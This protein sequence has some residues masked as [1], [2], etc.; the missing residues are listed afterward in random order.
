[1]R[2]HGCS[3]TDRLRPTFTNTS[4][5]RNKEV[6]KIYLDYA[7]TCPV[8]PEVLSAMIPFFCDLFGNPSSFHS[9]GQDAKKALENARHTVACSIG[10]GP[11]EVVFTSGGTESDN[12]AIKGV[13]YRN[14]S[15]GNHI[16][17]S[18]IEHHAVLNPCRFLQQEGFDVTVLPVDSTGTVDPDDVRKAITPKTVLISVM[19][20][21]NEIGTIEPIAVIG[22]IARE[23]EVLFHTDAVQTYGHLPINVEELHTDLLSASAHKLYGPKGVG[24]LY[25]KKG[26]KIASFMHGGE[27]EQGRRGS[28]HNLPG[29]VGLGKAAEIA[30]RLMREED[31]KQKH[32]RD[33]LIRG[34][35]ERIPRTKLNGHPV[36]RLPNNVNI[37]VSEVEG[38][39]MMLE[40]DMGGIIC[41]TGSA[42]SSM[43]LESSHV[44]LSLG[45]THELAHGS[46]RFS[47]GRYTEEEDIERV[48]ELFPAIV[49]RLRALSPLCGTGR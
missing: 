30:G 17:T 34:I 39:S 48:L 37:A 6:K 20:A 14:R 38:E 44:L 27:Q 2:A 49:R 16:I 18:S 8:D 19:H 1:M 3:K 42:C 28:T 4:T 45:L 23:H 26:T 24:F 15:R 9:Y 25:V 40:L 13:A 12:F 10:A 41:S 46:L 7:A 5:G 29:I 31:E 11:D 47:L 32:Y 33:M 36:R 43:S 22:T 35:E 21:N